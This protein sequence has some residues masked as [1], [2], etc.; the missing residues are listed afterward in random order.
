MSKSTITYQPPKNHPKTSCSSTPLSHFRER[1]GRCRS[2]PIPLLLLLVSFTFSAALFFS[3]IPVAPV[4][5]GQFPNFLSYYADSCSSSATDAL[6][7]M[8]SD[9]NTM[10]MFE[11][12]LKSDSSALPI[13]ILHARFVYYSEYRLCMLDDQIKSCSFYHRGE[14]LLDF[15]VTGSPVE[16]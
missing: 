16:H 12:V 13:L 14:L 10:I 11:P 2:S 8:L 3:S 9:L 6:L 1:R 7:M 15:R 4:V 5:V